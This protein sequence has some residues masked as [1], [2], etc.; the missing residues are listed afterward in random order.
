MDNPWY[1]RNKSQLQTRKINKQVIAG[2]YKEGTHELIDLSACLV[3]HQQLNHVTQIVKSILADL[4]IPI[5]NERKHDGEV[6]TIV[7]RIGFETK[8][9][10]LVLITNTAEL[11][12]KDLFIKEVRQKLPEVTSL[13]QNINDSKTSLIFGEQ[14]YHL[15]G[16]ET[17]NERLGEFSFDLSARAFF[18]IK[19]ETNGSFV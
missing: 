18:S 15:D 19:P 11:S 4:N 1:Y 17:I 3:Q 9:V 13:M 8:Q 2:L 14:T 10:Q 12:N 7:T 5:Y 16:E 6:R